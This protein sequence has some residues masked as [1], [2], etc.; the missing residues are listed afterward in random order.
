MGVDGRVDEVKVVHSLKYLDVAARDA[1]L[2]WVFQPARLQGEPV[3]VWVEV[4]V[5]FHR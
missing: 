3:A 4:P 2:Q 5:E 1:V